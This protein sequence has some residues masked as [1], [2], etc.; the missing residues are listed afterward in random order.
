MP[1]G[2]RPIERTYVDV[3]LTNSSGFMP[4]AIARIDSN[5]NTYITNNSHSDARTAQA[6]GTWITNDPFPTN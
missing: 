5:G 4:W 3:A 1:L 2:F 6:F